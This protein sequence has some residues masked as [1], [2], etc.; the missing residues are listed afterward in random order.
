MCKNFYLIRHDSEY[1][2]GVGTDTKL[3]QCFWKEQAAQ[4][5]VI[6]FMNYLK[7]SLLRF[8]FIFAKFTGKQLSRCFTFSKVALVQIY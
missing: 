3:E 8:H 7:D 2:F 5:A 6:K 4:V 1:A